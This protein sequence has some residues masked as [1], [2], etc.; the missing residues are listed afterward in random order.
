MNNTTQF[1]DSLMIKRGNPTLTPAK[2][3]ATGLIYGL[4]AGRFNLQSMV[5]I[6]EVKG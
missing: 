4:Q 1:V 2:L 6:S 3:Y 5:N